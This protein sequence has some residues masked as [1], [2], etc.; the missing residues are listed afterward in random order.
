MYLTRKQKLICLV[1]FSLFVK[2]IVK[3]RYEPITCF[4]AFQAGL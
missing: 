3:M 2:G 1:P 4:P